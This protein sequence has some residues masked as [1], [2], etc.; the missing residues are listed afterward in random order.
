VCLIA[1]VLVVGADTVGPND[2][3]G[4]VDEAHE[5]IVGVGVV[6]T[7]EVVGKQVLALPIVNDARGRD[8]VE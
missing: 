6:L 4:L 2:A 1:D 3:V 8:L 5:G 7:A